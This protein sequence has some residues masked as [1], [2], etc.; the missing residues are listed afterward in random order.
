MGSYHEG[1]R[2]QILARKDECSA[3]V[4]PEGRQRV[5]GARCLSTFEQAPRSDGAH[6]MKCRLIVD[7]G[8]ATP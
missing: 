2:G 5:S 6:G 3:G 8:N 4:Y 1:T 7:R